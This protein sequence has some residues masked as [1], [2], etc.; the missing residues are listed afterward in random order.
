MAENNH[1]HTQA[2]KTDTD[3]M[4]NKRK[5]CIVI[6]TR[7]NYA[8]MKTVIDQIDGDPNL[9]L[10]ILVGGAA[11]LAKYGNF[12]DTLAGQGI[13]VNRTIHFLVDGENPMAMVKSAGLAVNEFA[14]AFDDLK[15]DVVIVIADRFECLAVTMAATFLNIPVAHIEG[16]EVSGSIDESVRHAITKMS[17]VHFPATEDAADRIRKLGEDPETI[18]VVGCTS[19]DMFNT[20]DLDDVGPAM[21]FQAGSGVG[22]VID[23]RQPFLLVVQHPVT[24][25]YEQNLANIG[26]TITAVSGLEM[27]TIWIAP[28]MD[29]GTDGVSKGIRVFR[30]KEKPDYIRFF[31]SL[32]IEYYARLLQNAA[33]VLGNSSSCIR[34]A[35]FLGTPAVNIG[36]RQQGR[37][38]GRNVV[39]VDYD[40]RAIRD[41]VVA[42]M[43]RGRLEPDHLYGD[44]TAGYRI[45]EVLGSCELKLQKR[46]TY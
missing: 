29:A 23:L 20:M 28:N 41:A 38:R 33:C 9:E 39:D 19:L 12:A 43:K 6:T 34:E 45:G 3:N 32:P 31:K 13:K 22:S 8:K 2:K 17:Q 26:Q 44:G 5:I 10:Q 1:A 40:H 4:S 27:N 14:T 37:Q 24:T 35:A 15:P 18:H 46:I 30:E 16:G 42:Q 36:T 7:G 21:E 11:I 25:E